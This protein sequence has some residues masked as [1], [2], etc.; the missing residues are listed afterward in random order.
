MLPADRE[1]AT[2]GRHCPISYA[3]DNWMRWRQFS[4]VASTAD[5]N[6]RRQLHHHRERYLGQRHKFRLAYPNCHLRPDSHANSA[7]LQ[8][9]RTL[10]RRGGPC[11][12]RTPIGPDHSPAAAK[13]RRLGV[14]V[15]PPT[16]TNSPR[17]GFSSLAAS[18]RSWRLGLAMSRP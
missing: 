1:S 14:A 5:G 4:S 16:K 9:K 15:H 3:T 7:H 11:V 13:P 18:T 2:L 17:I 10:M 6:S 8:C 12:L